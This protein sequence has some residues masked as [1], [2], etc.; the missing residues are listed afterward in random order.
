VNCFTTSFHCTVFNRWGKKVFETSD[1]HNGW[2]GYSFD[3]KILAGTYVY[4]IEYKTNTG[5][6]KTAKGVVVLMQ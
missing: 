5:N 2:N 3:N 1:V 6:I 4:Y